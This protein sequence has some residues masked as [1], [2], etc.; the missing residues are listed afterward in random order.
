MRISCA[1]LFLWEYSIQEIVGIL[2]EAG[3]R[4]IE[5]WT[6][7]PDFWQNRKDDTSV[8]LLK[9]VLS[10]F[11]EDPT[12]HAP[13]LDLNPSSYNEYIREITTRET[14]WSLDLANTLGARMITIH[15]GSRTVHRKPTPEDWERFFGYLG[16]CTRY[17][18]DLGLIL[19]LE[20]P[21]PSISNMCSNPG[22]MLDTLNA[23][24]SLMMTL[25]IAH[26]LYGSTELA[27]SF[28]E[29]LKDKIVNIHVGAAHD[30][31]PHYPLHL[32]EDRNMERV[33]KALK[34]AGYDGDLTIEIDDKVYEKPLTREDK[35][36]ELRLEREYLEDFFDLRFSQ[37]VHRKF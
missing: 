25:D 27:L 10:S 5:F 26:A 37:Q 18:R 9:E 30:A 8:I 33:L 36:R 22:E 23:F 12:L 15:A 6:E 1:S 35:I 17:A 24:P 16:D 14:L 2:S 20:N 29:E 7:T 19:T 11:T 32:R 21:M 4:S 31:R 34:E 13:V 28:V 3:V